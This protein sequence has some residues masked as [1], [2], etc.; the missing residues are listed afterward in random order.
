MF[1]GMIQ[2]GITLHRHIDSFT[3]AHPSTKKAM[4][5]F[6]PDYRLYSGAI[7]DVLYDHFLANDPRV[8]NNDSLKRFTSATY[9]HLEDNAIYLP[10]RFLQVFTYMKTDDWLY[11]YKFREG[12]QKSL[13]GLVRRATYLRET[14]TAYSLFNEH[15]SFLNGCYLEFFEDVKQYAKQ[16]MEELLG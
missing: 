3:D 2:K 12:M 13:H 5:V 14:E 16:K 8:F 7:M 11:H 6:R 9:R 15:Y 4:D 10:N 1:S